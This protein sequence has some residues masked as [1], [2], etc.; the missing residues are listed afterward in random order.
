MSNDL[1]DIAERLLA[2]LYHNPEHVGRVA[3]EEPVMPTAAAQR[4]WDVIEEVAGPDGFDTARVSALL[5]GLD[6]SEGADA[7]RLL[8]RIQKNDILGAVEA[9][10]YGHQGEQL[11]EWGAQLAEQAAK[12]RLATRLGRMASKIEGSGPELGLEEIRS[13][14]LSEVTSAT[15]SAQGGLQHV[16]A[17][18]DEAI[19]D[20]RSW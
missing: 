3:A 2:G 1:T 18:L 20:T 16:S 4:L 11:E 8:E 13:G 19:E 10:R 15:D 17:Y 14:V 5:S 9:A 6:G 7:K 12:Q